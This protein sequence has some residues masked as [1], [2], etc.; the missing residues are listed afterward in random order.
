MKTK[1][2]EYHIESHGLD[3]P[4][5]FEGVGIVGTCWDDVAVGCGDTE[6]AAYEDARESLAQRDWDVSS[7]P[8]ASDAG[9]DAEEVAPKDSEWWYYVAVYVRSDDTE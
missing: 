2:S 4:Q 5:Y 8:S 9:M 1:V 3:H 7:L 6:A